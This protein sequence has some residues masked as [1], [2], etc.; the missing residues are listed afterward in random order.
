ML[1]RI[2]E[3]GHC[4]CFNTPLPVVVLLMA[5]EQAKLFIC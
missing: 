1:D 5:D 2:H 4:L 3:K